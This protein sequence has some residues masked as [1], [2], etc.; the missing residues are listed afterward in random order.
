MSVLIT[1]MI[2][3]VMMVMTLLNGLNDRPFCLSGK[4]GPFLLRRVVRST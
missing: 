2:M 1:V 3:I 4:G